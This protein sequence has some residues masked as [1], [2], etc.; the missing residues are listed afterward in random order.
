MLAA[1]FAAG[2]HRSQE[3]PGSQKRRGDPK[4][5]QLHV[6]GARNV[7]GQNARQI[8]AEEVG[9]LR[10]IMLRGA[11]QQGL[12]QKQ[13]RHDQE[14]PGAGTLRRRER[15]FVRR[16]ERDRLF[17]AAVPA[18]KIPRPKAASR[19]P[20]AA[21]QGDQRKHAPNQRVRRGVIVHQRFR[22]PVVGVGIVQPGR[23]ADPAH[24]DQLKKAVSWRI[25]CGS[26]MAS[27][28]RPNF[29]VG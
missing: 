8:E 29:V 4:D 21:Q 9:K 18:Q 27:G 24:A 2:D 13:Q 16:P 23:R 1:R 3:N 25:C 7:E 17:L 22:R 5:R 10:A 28:R 19:Q 14:E 15:D 12:Q 20:N 26:V 6:P 11:A